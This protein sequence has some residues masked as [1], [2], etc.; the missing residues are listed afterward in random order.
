M[1]WLK[2]SGASVV[3]A[4]NPFHWAWIPQAGR[5]FRGEWAGPNEKGWYAKFLFLTIRGWVDDGSW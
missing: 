2:Y 1:N 4:L 5:D 3:F